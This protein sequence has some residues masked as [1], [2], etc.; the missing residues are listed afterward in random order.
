MG[1]L[2]KAFDCVCLSLL[3]LLFSLPVITLGAA[4][5]AL[6]RAAHLCLQKE[7]GYL[8]RTFWEAFRENFKRSTLCWLVVL[9]ILAVLVLDAVFFRGLLLKGDVFGK[10]YWVMLLLIC[11]VVTW[12]AFLSG[13][14]ARC[15][16]VSYQDVLICGETNLHGVSGRMV[17]MTL[18]IRPAGGNTYKCFRVSLAKDGEY[19][20]TLRYKPDTNILKIDRT[21]SGSNADIVHC[22]SFMVRPRAGELKLRVLMDRFSVEVF[23]N[24]G[25]QAASVAIFTRQE[26][27]AISFDAEGSVLLDVD[28]YDIHFD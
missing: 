23:V 24:D 16:R 22:R 3:W 13:Y 21:R 10:L 20:T 26:A 5:A 11:V 17:D 7:E 14:S 15:N 6:Y 18:N 9:A 4:S 8:L 1:F 19:V 12:M 28:K 2:L 27:Q 25:E